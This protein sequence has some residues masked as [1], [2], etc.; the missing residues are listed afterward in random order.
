MLVR[1]RSLHLMPAGRNKQ[2][3]RASVEDANEEIQLDA[4]L[5]VE[6]SADSVGFDRDSKVRRIRRSSRVGDS[7]R[8]Y[9]R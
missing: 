5:R 2:L 6:P 8:N 1:L 4:L 3:S 9:E 7:A